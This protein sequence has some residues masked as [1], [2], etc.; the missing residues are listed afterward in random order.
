[1][2]ILLSITLTTA[3]VL[4]LLCLILAVRVSAGRAKNNVIMG[5]GGNADMIIRMR[6]HANFVEYVPILLV[7]MGLLELGGGNRTVLIIF[8][9][10]LVLTRIMHAVGMARPAPSALR[11]IG[12]TG[13][14]LLLLLGAA[15]GLVLTWIVWNPMA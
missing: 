3:S 6:T 15:Y 1:M 10:V 4:A 14:F 12:A 8:G 13:T 7:L 2:P 9:V 11:A 5:D